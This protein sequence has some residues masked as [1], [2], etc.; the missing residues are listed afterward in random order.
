MRKGYV[1]VLV[2][3]C[4]GCEMCIPACPFSLMTFP[5]KTLN[6]AGYF[7]AEFDDSEE[8][9]T[10]CKMCA[11]ACPDAAIVVYKRIKEPAGGAK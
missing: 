3:R 9:C 8:K 10:A 7:I 6:K 1:E 5:M 4:K 11:T 2:N